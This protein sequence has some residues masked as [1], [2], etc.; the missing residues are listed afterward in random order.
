M[1]VIQERRKERELGYHLTKELVELHKGRIEVESEPGKGS[2]FKIIF[3]LGKDHLKTEEICE[4]KLEKDTRKHFH[5]M[6]LMN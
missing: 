6:K 3:L 5:L 4:E 2:I 1:A